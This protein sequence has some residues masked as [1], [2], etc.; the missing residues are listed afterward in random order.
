[1][2]I[3]VEGAASEAEALKVA[4]TIAHSPLVKTAFYAS[5]PNWG[6]I[7]AAVGYADAHVE[8]WKMQIYL[9][10]ELVVRNGGRVQKPANILNRIFAQKNI[11]VCIDLGLGKFSSHYYTSDLSTN[12]V[13]INSAY[14][15]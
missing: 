4:Y 13:R 8:P 1:M 15:T 5:D 10:K 7:A 9:G 11:R 14:S 2:H 12:Y 3:G 6:R